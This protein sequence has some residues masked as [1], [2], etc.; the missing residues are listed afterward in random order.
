MFSPC[1]L[2]CPNRQ[3]IEAATR[4]CQQL[5]QLKD[6][7]VSHGGSKGNQHFIPYLNAF[8]KYAELLLFETFNTLL[9][10]YAYTPT[11]YEH[12]M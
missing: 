3:Y 12:Y 2:R 6:T 11:I 1:I 5:Q 4:Y 7:P 8:W 9:H 10:N